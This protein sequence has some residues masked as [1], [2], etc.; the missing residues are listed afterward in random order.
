[1][2]SITPIH[3]DLTDYRAIVDMKDWKFDF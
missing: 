2:I 1:M 3:L